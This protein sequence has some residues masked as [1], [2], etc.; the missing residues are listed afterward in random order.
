MAG[1]CV[2]SMLMLCWKKFLSTQHPGQRDRPAQESAGSDW[3][4]AVSIVAA[5]V[6][7]R[8]LIQSVVPSTVAPAA[9]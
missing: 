5:L 8:L 3:R 7:A 1:R 6:C 4:Y 9:E 2:E